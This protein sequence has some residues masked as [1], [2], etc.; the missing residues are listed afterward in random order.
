MLPAYSTVKSTHLY[1]LAGNFLILQASN[2]CR[3]L[4]STA[5][6]LDPT[7]WVYV[8]PGED[9]ES[10]VLHSNTATAKR[11]RRTVIFW[12]LKTPLLSSLADPFIMA[13][14]PE[15]MSGSP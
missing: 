6:Y 5:Q 11:D 2:P 3:P 8:R 15:Q 4:G 14:S 10:D 12:R 7:R 1:S 9:K 13:R